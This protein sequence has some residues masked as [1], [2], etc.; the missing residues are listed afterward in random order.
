MMA[1]VLFLAL[2][3][4]AEEVKDLESL[5]WS[6][7]HTLT[8]LNAH[9]VSPTIV[10]DEYGL[11][12]LFQELRTFGS[13][14]VNYMFSPDLGKSWKNERVLSTAYSMGVGTSLMSHEG[15]LHAVWCPT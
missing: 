2:P 9:A 12:V 13:A 8:S 14:T 10:A 3:A 4:S 1:L 11:H 15:I 6:R 7:E 5:G